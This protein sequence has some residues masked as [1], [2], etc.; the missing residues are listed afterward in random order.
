MVPRGR[1]PWEHPSVP[2]VFRHPI[3]TLETEPVVGADGVPQ[4]FVRL[5][6][7]D[8]VAVVPRTSDGRYTLVEQRRHG[9]G[10]LGL[11]PVGGVVEVGESPEDTARRELVEET[12]LGGGELV[13]LGVVWP[14]PALQ[15]NRC[16]LFLARRVAPVA[17]PRPDPHEALVVRALTTR[18]V[19]QAL[20]DGRVH[21]AL[22]ALALERA[23]RC[24]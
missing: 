24:E 3:L 15:D 1:P 11:E 20:A 10:R 4:T 22:G 8:W 17:A 12:G 6:V 21:A 9:S 19:E 2:V 23:L 7:P 16:W 13:S 14:N 5:R 18:E